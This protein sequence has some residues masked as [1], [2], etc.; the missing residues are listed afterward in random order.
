MQ[1]AVCDYEKNIID[2]LARKQ[3]VLFKTRQKTYTLRK[4]DIYYIENQLKKIVIHTA[5]EN[6]EVYGSMKDI[7]E[8]LDDGFYRCHRGYLVN[9]AHIRAYGS[10]S[11][12]LTNGDN[13]F[14]SKD[15]YGDFENAYMTYLQDG[16]L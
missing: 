5:I 7:E 2:S 8:K 6:I 15:K 3:I 1:I 11:I 12:Q 4:N 14:L 9:M 10:S 13:I 16:K